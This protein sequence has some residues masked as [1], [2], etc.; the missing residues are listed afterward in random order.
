MGLVKHFYANN[1]WLD[2]YEDLM[3]KVQLIEEVDVRAYEN[4]VQF[5]E[6]FLILTM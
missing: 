2:D 3:T 5:E 1:M 4:K 6:L